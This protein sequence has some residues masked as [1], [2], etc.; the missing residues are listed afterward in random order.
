MT[1][2]L[3]D[4][5]KFA[6]SFLGEAYE[7]IE[8]LRSEHNAYLTEM[9]VDYVLVNG[10]RYPKMGNTVSIVYKFKDKGHGSI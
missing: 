10:I 7:E 6:Y 2:D 1:E 8:R 9:V 4:R 3:V 5:L